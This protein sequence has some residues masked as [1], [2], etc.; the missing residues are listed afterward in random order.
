[1]ITLSRDTGMNIQS[2]VSPHNP[3]STLP[4]P[5]PSDPYDPFELDKESQSYA[6][7]RTDA[8]VK[9]SQAPQ[10]SKTYLRELDSLNL[11][12]SHLKHTATQFPAKRQVRSSLKR[13]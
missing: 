3:P 8:V 9:R 5:Y 10:V 11:F 6:K 4:S 13:P 7:G 2:A 1:M 12:Y